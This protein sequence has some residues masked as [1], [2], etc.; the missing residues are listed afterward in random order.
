MWV[1]YNPINSL[2]ELWRWYIVLSFYWFFYFLSASI[3]AVLSKIDTLAKRLTA[4]TVFQHH[5]ISLPNGQIF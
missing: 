4:D 3:Y 1:C 5:N 2:A